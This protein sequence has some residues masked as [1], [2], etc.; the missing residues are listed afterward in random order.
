MLGLTQE[1]YTDVQIAINIL[2]LPTAKWSPSNIHTCLTQL[3]WF[4]TNYSKFTVPT[5]NLSGLF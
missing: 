5:V 1:Q 2:V 4:K 3:Q